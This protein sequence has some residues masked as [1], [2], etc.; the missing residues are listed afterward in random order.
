MLGIFAIVIVPAAFLLSP[1][2]T[3]IYRPKYNDYVL[4]YTADE[5]RES[6][7]VFC[8]IMNNNNNKCIIDRVAQTGN[9]Y[10]WRYIHLYSLSFLFQ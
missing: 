9:S 3:Y 4:D 10:T 7:S 2:H 1:N 8:F 6:F 5:V